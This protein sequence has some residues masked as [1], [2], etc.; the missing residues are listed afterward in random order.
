MAESYWVME[1]VFAVV[2]AV[3]AVGQFTAI[4]RPQKARGL[5]KWQEDC[6]PITVTGK[7]DLINLVKK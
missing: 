1:S 7:S 4:G 2:M 5:R 3:A 6:S